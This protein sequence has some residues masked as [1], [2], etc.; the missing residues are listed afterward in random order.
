M[1]KQKGMA[2][3]ADTLGDHK[4]GKYMEKIHGVRQEKG[5]NERLASHKDTAIT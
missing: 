2:E 5:N 3:Y 4:E 1:T